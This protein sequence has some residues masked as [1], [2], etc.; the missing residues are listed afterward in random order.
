MDTWEINL[1]T[2]WGIY[3]SPPMVGVIAG[4]ATFQDMIRKTES[5]WGN[6]M[7]VEHGVMV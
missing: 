3:E 2:L 6:A 4:L 1:F 7:K 5:N